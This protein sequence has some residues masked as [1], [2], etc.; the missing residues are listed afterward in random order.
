MRQIKERATPPFAPCGSMWCRQ[1]SDAGPEPI[2]S[3]KTADVEGPFAALSRRLLAGVT[4]L[5]LAAAGTL[6]HAG[7]Y[8]IEGYPDGLSFTEGDVIDFHVSSAFARYHV[9]IQRI[10]ASRE[11][12]W[13]RDIENGT[14]QRIPTDASARGCGWPVSFSVRVPAAWKSGYYE[15]YFGAPA[16]DN[17][18]QWTEGR[19]AFFVIRAKSPGAKAKILL[20]LATNTYNAYDNWGGHS[21]YAFN[22]DRGRQGSRVSFSRPITS[23]ASEW[24]VPFIEWA[25][26]NGYN[27]EYAVNSDLEF[28]PELLDRYRLVLSVGHDEYWSAP[29]RDTI[30]RFISNG[31]NLAF[32]GGNS[33]TW[34]VRFENGGTEM[35]CWKHAYREDPLYNPTGSS[36]LL[37]TLWGHPLVNRPENALV[38]A[39]TMFGGM[40]RSAGQY[41]DGSGAFTVYRPGHWVFAGTGLKQ[42]EQ[43]GARDRIVGYECDGCEHRFVN[44][45]PVPT[46]RDGTPDGFLILALAPASWPADEWQWYE[47][48]ESGRRGNA[49]MGLHEIAAGGT[50]FTAATTGWAH[51]L[52]GKDP[53]VEIIT[54]N[55]LDR[56]SR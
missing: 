47:K 25:E 45:R 14:R 10:G 54:R 30:E 32:F 3:M 43:F 2:A 37:S 17:K 49:C 23:G 44:G 12:V 55:V 22:S 8:P 46:Q 56:L 26:R 13:A 24:E 48:W 9:T 4:F 11:T 18:E 28:H 39:G 15:V 19:T 50:V 53:I 31:G 36:P 42:G 40:H 41:V 33:L 29:M 16:A 52:Q 34:Q 7:E 5:V 51:G 21:L 6:C 38:G 27:L 1:A 20:Q 35:V